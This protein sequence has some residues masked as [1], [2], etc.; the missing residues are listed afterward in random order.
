MEIEY[1]AKFL[2]IDKDEVRARLK[3]ADAKLQRPEFLQRRWVL[4]LPSETR[5]KGVWLRV[6][7]EGDKITM[8]WKSQTGTAIDDQKELTVV[9]D[10]FDKAVQF[11]E[12][13][14]CPPESYQETLRELWILDD[15]EIT[16]DTWPFM[17]PFVEVEAKSETLVKKACEKVGFSWKD[18]FFS[19]VNHV[20][21]RKYGERVHIRTMPKLTFDM[22]NPFV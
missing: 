2:N 17:E 16:I 19:G 15:A 13:L 1:E 4:D 5:T 6:R 22:A 3:K 11:L 20:Y 21:Q 12:L 7:D 10:D 9:V 8:S 18:A 14:G